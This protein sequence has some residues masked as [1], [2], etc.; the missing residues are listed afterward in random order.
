MKTEY[1]NPKAERIPK[2]EGRKDDKVRASVSDF[3]FFPAHV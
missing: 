1:R 3:G 2:T